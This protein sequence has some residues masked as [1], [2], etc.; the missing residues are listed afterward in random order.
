MTTR[1]R[2]ALLGSSLLALVAGGLLSLACGLAAGVAGGMAG[3]SPLHGSGGAGQTGGPAGGA[4]VTVPGAAVTAT[5]KVLNERMAWWN[6]ARLGMF[7]HFGLYALPAGVW[8]GKTS[9]GEWIRTDAQIPL[10]EYDKLLTQFNPTKFDA[11][12]IVLAAKNAGMKYITITTK[13]HDGF[14][15]FDSKV[16]DFDVMNTPFKRDIMKEMADACHKHGVKICWYYSI[17][18]WHHPDYTPRRDWE[19]DRPTE[20][21][22]YERYLAYM[23]AQLKELLTNYGEIGLL[24]FDGQWEGTWNDERGRDLEAY[25]RSL[26]PSIIINSRVGRGG[27]AY[28]LAGGRLGDY[29]TPEQEIPESNPGGFWETCMTMNGHW[30]YNAADKNFKS[31]QDLVQKT[32]DIASKG[33]NFLLNVGPTSAGE[34]PPESLQRM[35]EMG[36]WMKINEESVRGTMASPFDKPFAW[37]RCTTRVTGRHEGSGGQVTSSRLYLSVFDWPKDGKLRVPGLLNEV[38]KASIL[39]TTR[40]VK[41]AR[42]GDALVLDV[43]ATPTNP[44]ATV[45]ALDLAQWPDVTSA[46]VISSDADV[47]TD[48]LAVDIKTT[49]KN[50]QLRYTIDGK[51]PTAKSPV[52]QGPVTMSAGGMVKA[53]AFRGDKVVSPVA[54]KTFTRVTAR[55]P[56]PHGETAKPGL[57]FEAFKLAGDIKLLSEVK[58]VPAAVTGVSEG[59]DLSKR[60]AE[61]N[62]AYRFTGAIDVP[63]TGVYRFFVASDDGSSMSIGDKLV[64]DNDKPHS[65][66]EESGVIALEKGLHPITLEFFENWGGYELKVYWQGP[67]MSKVLIPTAALRHFGDAA[68]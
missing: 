32:V 48:A 37:G 9:Y 16:S 63:A 2:A 47:F 5:D 29:A 66:H 19:K 55:A 31:T 23:K 41:V 64:V 58:G 36:E 1:P 33:G 20:G 40:S 27:G 68:K 26:Q 35:A 11:E 34:I 17:M 50:V 57:R 14:A 15:L 4:Q 21:A 7:I 45:V 13:H 6:D 24:W 44:Y 12:K 52:V 62:F 51:E 22:D 18:D 3:C 61:K 67:G 42:D 46:P 8:N 59:F 30:G 43:G 10:A 53:R 25:V 60:P 54:E 56:M 28:G 38:E 65:L 39:G 49:Q